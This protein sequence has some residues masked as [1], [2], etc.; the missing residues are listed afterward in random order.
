MKP[1]VAVGCRG[2]GP[3]DIPMIAM[4]EDLA[5]SLTYESKLDRSRENIDK[6]DHRWRK[7]RAEIY[8]SQLQRNGMMESVSKS[9]VCMPGA[10][11]RHFFRKAADSL[12]SLTDVSLLDGR[13]RR[14]P[15]RLTRSGQ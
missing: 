4:S 7:T 11:V 5:C 15:A 9:R 6:T 13:D 1:R 12:V 10:Q 8:R 3:Y 14:V 2:G